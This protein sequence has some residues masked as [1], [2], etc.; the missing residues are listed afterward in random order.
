M[1]I[2]RFAIILLAGL[3][4]APSLVSAQTAPLSR[5][6][7]ITF[8][9]VVTDSV[10]DTIMVR[11]ATGALMP[12]TGPLPDFPYHVGDEVTISF[13]ADLPTRAFVDEYLASHGVPPSTDG[14]YRIGVASCYYSGCL[15]PVG[16]ASNIDVSGPINPELNFGQ[17]TNMRM[18]IIYDYNTDSYSIDWGTSTLP[19][20]FVAGSFGGPGLLYDPVTGLYV[21]CVNAS[22]CRGSAAVDPVLFSLYANGDGSVVQTSGI[23]INAIGGATE[24][25][26]LGFFNLGFTGSWNLP[27]YA[28][29]PTQVP[30]PDM[31]LLFGLAAGVMP[32]RRWLA[33]R[34]R[35][36]A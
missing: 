11:D 30:E 20:G 24:P 16:A 6:V 22:D 19:S 34:Q 2:L 31:L 27:G 8:T 23:A 25:T 15:T 35:A 28:A 7:P 3:L 5:T 29:N 26:G 9:G 13:N 12:Y 1:A 21:P 17:P 18:D 33:R 10:N 32:L 36:M 4:V 14:T